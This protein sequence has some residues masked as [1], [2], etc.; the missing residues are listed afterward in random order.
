MDRPIPSSDALFDAWR[1]D[2][3]GWGVPEEILAAAPESPWGFPGKVFAR[4]AES[5]ILAREGV[6]FQRASEALPEGG[7]L[8]DVGAGAGAAS[9]PHADRASRIVAVDTDPDMLAALD[10]VVA[11]NPGFRARVEVHQGIWPDVAPQTPV[12]DVVVCHHVLYNVADLRPFV[13]ELTAHARIRVV[14]ELTDRHPMEPMG[15]LWRQF[16]GLARPAGPSAAQAGEAIASLGLDVG[17]QRWGAAP[18]HLYDSMAEMV[19]FHRRRLCLP[20]SEDPAVAAALEA[21]GVDPQHPV[22]LGAG[23]PVVT[24]WWPGVA[25]ATE[26]AEAGGRRP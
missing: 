19:A 13:Q 1:A 4:R 26:Q 16:H 14:V 24:L 21:L 18:L 5:Q 8:M 15:P 17:M 7:T 12:V 2:L 22:G 3:S 10:G 6:S 23:R 11:G 25:G 20:A 9:L